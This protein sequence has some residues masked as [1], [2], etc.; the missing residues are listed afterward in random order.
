[1]KRYFYP[2]LACVLSLSCKPIEPGGT[3]GALHE[4]GFDYCESA[5][6]CNDSSI[7]DRLAVP[8]TFRLGFSDGDVTLSSDSPERLE[9]T[10]G[11]DAV[12]TFRALSAGNVKISAR[13]S[14]EGK[15]V[16]YV[17]VALVDLASLQIDQCPRAFNAITT[18]G[19]SF[20]PGDCGGAPSTELAFSRGD[21]LSPTVCLRMRDEHGS[22]LGGAPDATWTASTSSSAELQVDVGSDS[23]CATI[24]GLTVGQA[25]VVV[26]VAGIS[27]PL[28]VTVTP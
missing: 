7:P 20:D 16:D 28:D 21:S 27:A 1:M 22:E 10:P 2:G 5:D 13:T 26:D 11:S 24:G 12:T 8:S 15:L 9:A 19:G 18:S 17:T 14:S 23:R 25:Q 6:P 4:G 3:P